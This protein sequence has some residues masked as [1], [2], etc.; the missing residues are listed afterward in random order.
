MKIILA[1]I[2]S[3]IA[4]GFV[5]VAVRRPPNEYPQAAP[6]TTGVWLAETLPAHPGWQQASA[7]VPPCR[8]AANFAFLEP[9]GLVPVADIEPQSMARPAS[10]SPDKLGP[11]LQPRQ[12]VPVARVPLTPTA[13]E[14]QS[15]QGTGPCLLT[16]GLLNGG[17]GANGTETPRPRVVTRRLFDAIRWVESGGDDL[18][19]GDFGRSV[20]PY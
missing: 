5:V 13:L 2:L 15:A 10:S 6:R 12:V 20:G 3:F 9:G 11:L 18:A 17:G 14:P 1:A 4:A 19:V 8:G 7:S 16:Q